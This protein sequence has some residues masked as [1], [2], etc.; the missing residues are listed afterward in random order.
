MKLLPRLRPFN[1]YILVSWM[2]WLICRYQS[3][4]MLK[5]FARGIAG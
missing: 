5:A 1:R 4:R 3:A 2:L